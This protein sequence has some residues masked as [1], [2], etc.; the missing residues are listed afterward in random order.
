M[1]ANTAIK[2]AAELAEVLLA[3]SNAGCK[4]GQARQRQAELWEALDGWEAAMVRRGATIVAE[5]TSMT[6]SI[7]A[8]GFWQ[9][10]VVRPYVLPAMSRVVA[11]VVWAVQKWRSLLLLLTD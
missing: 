1:G 5:S 6:R 9:T 11:A 7:H 2:D 8:T 3:H 4:G 10:R